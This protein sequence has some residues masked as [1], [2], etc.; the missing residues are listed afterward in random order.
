[1]P[2]RSWT[3]PCAQLT[4]PLRANFDSVLATPIR[5]GRKRREHT[6]LVPRP[7]DESALVYK[8][9]GKVVHGDR[10]SVGVLLFTS[11]F[12]PLFFDTIEPE[13]FRVHML[14]LEE[15]VPCRRR[16]SATNGE[17]VVDGDAVDAS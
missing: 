10:L 11:S 5:K 7:A 13:F 12:A 16:I 2:K 6:C 4:I 15:S 17:R 3:R 8:R 9:D 14:Q 1:M